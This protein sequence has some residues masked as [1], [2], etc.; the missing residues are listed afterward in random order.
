MADSQNVGNVLLP[1]NQSRHGGSD[2]VVSPDFL[3]AVKVEHDTEP[4]C[5][6][7]DLEVIESVL[8]AFERVCKRGPV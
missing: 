1:R 7:V 8:L 2:W 3:R 4:E 5:F 6:D